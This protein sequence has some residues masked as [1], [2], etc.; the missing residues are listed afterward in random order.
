MDN[1]LAKLVIKDIRTYSILS[2]NE[3][4]KERLREAYDYTKSIGV[5][6]V[7]EFTTRQDI[8]VGAFEYDEITIFDRIVDPEYTKLLASAL[9][10]INNSREAYID[11]PRIGDEL[12]SWGTLGYT[13]YREQLILSGCI[14]VGLTEEEKN[15]H[16]K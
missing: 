9:F 15:R 13:P 2:R 4:Y 10:N 6:S 8:K 7:E 12:A 5:T 3:N 16:Y 14:T 11:N 1:N